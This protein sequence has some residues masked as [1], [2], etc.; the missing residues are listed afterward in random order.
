MFTYLAHYYDTFKDEKPATPRH[1]V[2][3]DEVTS[4]DI[5]MNNLRWPICAIHKTSAQCKSSVYN[6]Q[7]KLNLVS[8]QN[9]FDLNA[10]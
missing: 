4:P 5:S 9:K 7:S 10:K 1:S 2:S 3:S 6:T 8:M